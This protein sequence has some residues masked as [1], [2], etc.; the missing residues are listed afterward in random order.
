[1][2]KFGK[3]VL[4]ASVAAMAASFGATGAQAGI[5]D[6]FVIAMENQN[7]TVSGTNSSGL[8]PIYGNPA[9][10][11]INSLITPGD[12]NAQYTA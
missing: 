8:N 7:A 12:P 2:R 1:M 9:A 6:V 11:Y 5:G 10:P 3:L 4:S